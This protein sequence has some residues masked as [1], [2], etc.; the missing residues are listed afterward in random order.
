MTDK[1]VKEIDLETGN[2]TERPMT[3]EEIADI[4]AI[5]AQSQAMREGLEAASVARQA[6]L[7]RLGLTEEEAQ[8]ILGGSN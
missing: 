8:L 4:A 5:T 1:I 2:A 3:A 7:D 6:V